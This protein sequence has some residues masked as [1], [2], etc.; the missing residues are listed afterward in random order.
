MGVGR[1]RLYH[2]QALFKEPGGGATPWHQD[3]YYWPLDTGNMIT[4]WMPLVDVTVEMGMLTFATGSH[5]EGLVRNVSISD[6][7]EVALNDL[8]REKGF[9]ISRPDFLRAGD[10]T[11]HYG[12]TLHRAPGNDSEIMRE[13]MTVIYFADGARVT[14]PQ[15]E[16]QEADRQRWLGGIEPGELADGPLNP[17]I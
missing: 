9:E 1:V 12:L 5:K 7:S 3:Q 4:M 16:H 17:V 6:A 15:S 8:V 13:V 14:H 2:D 10:A 11:W